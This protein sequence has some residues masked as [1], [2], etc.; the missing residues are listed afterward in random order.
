LPKAGEIAQ[1]SLI[2]NPS[3]ANLG[4]FPNAA[5]GTAVVFLQMHLWDKTINRL[6]LYL[7]GL[8]WHNEKYK[9]GKNKFY[10]FANVSARPFVY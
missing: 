2:L 1:T 4:W 8:Q 5:V 9:N 10:L 3:E 7:A 6:A